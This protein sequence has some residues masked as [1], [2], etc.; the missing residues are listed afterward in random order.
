MNNAPLNGVPLNGAPEETNGGGEGDVIEASI[1][2]QMSA[3]DAALRIFPTE[4][5]S[6]IEAGDLV[7]DPLIA[8][9]LVSRINGSASMLVRELNLLIER[10]RIAPR[11]ISAAEFNLTALSRL[12]ARDAA[13]VGYAARLVSSVDGSDVGEINLRRLVAASSAMRL[14]GVASNRMSSVGLLASLA[15]LQDWT[16]Q[17]FEGSVLDA[18]EASDVLSSKFVGYA[19]L[20]EQ[21][22]IASDTLAGLSAFVRVP[23]GIDLIDALSASQRLTASVSDGVELSLEL[24]FQGEAYDAWVVN[25]TGANAAAFYSN[26]SFNSMARIGMRYYGA[27]EQGFFRL[28]GD[29]DDGEP[30]AARVLTG[31]LDFGTPALKRVLE[32]H[33]GCIA[34][35]DLVLKIRATIDGE[36]QEFWYRA[37]MPAVGEPT[38]ARVQNIGRGLASRYLQFEIA[39]IDGI[40]FD[41]DRVDLRLLQLSRRI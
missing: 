29:D 8:A 25:T 27:S 20:I 9:L 24:F 40:D 34:K 5:T 18:L 2:D 3:S 23:D 28:D 37:S 19:A 22:L 7:P 26:Y 35:G 17:S 4:S 38:E 11:L 1:T 36:L 12:S 32:A 30:I 33:I 31:E 21:A 10:L 39:N 15:A 41:L 14:L 6:D 13:R 16:A